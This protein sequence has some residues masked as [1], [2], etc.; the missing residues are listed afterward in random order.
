[1]FNEMREGMF[2]GCPYI[3]TMNNKG[4]LYFGFGAGARSVRRPRLATG[5]MS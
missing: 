1:M 4:R 3:E 2:V 5:G